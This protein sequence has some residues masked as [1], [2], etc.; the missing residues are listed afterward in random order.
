MLAVFLLKSKFFQ[1]RA[2]SLIGFSLGTVATMHCARILKGKFR[3]GH[4]KASRILSEIQLWA[5]AFVIDPKK[6]YAERMRAAFHLS[7][8]NGRVSNLYSFADNVL[9]F[10]QPEVH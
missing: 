10:M 7:I 2:I 8:C 6:N 9:T 1:G 3:Q 5:G 4:V